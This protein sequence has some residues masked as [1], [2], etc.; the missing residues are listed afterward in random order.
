MM[1]PRCCKN[2]SNKHKGIC[3]C[4][5]PNYCNEYVEDDDLKVTGTSISFLEDGTM[6]HTDYKSKTEYYCTKCAEK[7]Q[8][9]KELEK[10]LK[11]VKQE[12]RKLS[13]KNG[14]YK[15]K[16]ETLLK[17]WIDS[18]GGKETFINEET[19]KNELQTYNK[20]KLIELYLQMRFERDV[21]K[22]L[23]E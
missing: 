4:V 1:I 13:V 10:E 12:K 3:N 7:E 21:W 6:I 8:R 19:L 23:E 15:R 22:D 14:R 18:L 9:I 16:V 11:K 2:C 20:D 5:L 17:Y